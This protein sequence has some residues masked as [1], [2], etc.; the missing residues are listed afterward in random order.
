M[1]LLKQLPLYS[2]AQS[3]A[4]LKNCIISNQF[5]SLIINE[6]K[7]EKHSGIAIMPMMTKFRNDVI[8]GQRLI[9]ELLTLK[10]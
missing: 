8:K 1:I 5:S 6:K 3:K 9:L 2:I 4:T 7:Q 10:E